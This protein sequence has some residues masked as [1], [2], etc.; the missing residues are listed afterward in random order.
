MQLRVLRR[1]TWNW[2]PVFLSVAETGSVSEASRELGITPAAVSRTLRLLEDHLGR[3]LFTRSGRSLRLNAA[4][5]QMRGSIRAAV[6]EVDVGLM[7]FQPE[8]F[9]G[10][11]RVAADGALNDHFVLPALLELRNEH[12]AF[13]PDQQILA[14]R[15]ISKA[16]CLGEVDVAFSDH[17]IE[18]EG[19]DCEAIGSYTVGVYCGRSHAFYGH[20][21]L[22][23]QA[24][25]KQ[26]FC[27]PSNSG[28]FAC[29][30]GWPRAWPRQIAIRVT[31]L[32]AAIRVACEGELLAVLPD[33]AVVNECARGEL[34]RLSLPQLP[35]RDVYCTTSGLGAQRPVAQAI[36]TRV[37]ERLLAAQGRATGAFPILARG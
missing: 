2:L 21:G 28:Y 19:T 11:V 25:G 12:P 35:A 30:D 17:A 10:V 15:D 33:I 14:E 22:N 37:R 29:P 8:P 3:P 34:H 13:S 23:Q 6:D 26:P 24:I 1:S 16:L 7:A 32:S 20:E 31:L 5:L 36:R 27:A 9:N 18:D 4:G